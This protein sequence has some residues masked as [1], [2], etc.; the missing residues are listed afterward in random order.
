[1]STRNRHLGQTDINLNGQNFV[2]EPNQLK[3]DWP[4]FYT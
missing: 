1:M 4:E 3:F 2:L